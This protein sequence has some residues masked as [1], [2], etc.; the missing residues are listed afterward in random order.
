MPLTLVGCLV[1][2]AVGRAD[3]A[4][5]GATVGETGTETQVGEL[6]SPSFRAQPTPHPLKRAQSGS[7]RPINRLLHLVK[8]A[9]SVSGLCIQLRGSPVGRMEGGCLEPQ[10][11]MTKHRAQRVSDTL[12]PEGE[13]EKEEENEEGEEELPCRIMGGWTHQ[14]RHD[15]RCGRRHG[16]PLCNQNQ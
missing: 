8:E 11:S 3:G 15:G 16:W 9:L 2:A 4:V 13:K 5:V 6:S 14:G 1:G 10:H 7:S 12:K